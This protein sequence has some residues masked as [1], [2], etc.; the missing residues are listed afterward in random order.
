MTESCRARTDFEQII[1]IRF[2]QPAL[3]EAA[4]T[5]SSFVN[6]YTG[7]DE[8]SDNE[9]LEFLGDA[10]LDLVAAELLF[11]QYPH[12]DEGALTQL[13]AALVKTESLAR[14]AAQFQL[15]D[16]LRFGKGEELSGGR[17][18]ATTL[19]RAFEALIGA[20]YLDQGMA[21]ATDFLTPLLLDLLREVLDKSLHLDARSELMELLLSRQMPEPGYHV[22]G[23]SG[24]EHAKQFRVEVRAGKATLGCGTGKSKRVASQSA[25]R[26]ALRRMG[27]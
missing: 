23:E 21:S 19:S 14:F 24:P 12:I 9:R 16:G 10:V 25:A 11:R 18:R 7:A 2:R 5:H 27:S 17:K 26:D 6:E 8:V 15:G 13:R 4:L 3:L 22:V 1:G 20:I